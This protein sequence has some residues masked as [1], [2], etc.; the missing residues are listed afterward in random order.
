VA[1]NSAYKVELTPAAKRDVRKLPS[2]V[3]KQVL[4]A[5]EALGREPRPQGSRKLTGAD[6]YR[7]RVGEY[8][9][10]YEIDDG[11]SE[12]RVVKV[13]DR[14]DVYRFLGH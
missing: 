5:I 2:H 1:G 8:R 3:Q 11:R 6:L 7:V 12:V 14:R 10:I 4:D 13:G 9:V